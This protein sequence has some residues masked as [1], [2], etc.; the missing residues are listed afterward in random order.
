M[1]MIT[2]YIIIG[3]L[4][5]ILFDDIRLRWI[6][7]DLM[8]KVESLYSSVIELKSSNSQ[9]VSS[10]N[11]QNKELLNL[12]N[13]YLRYKSEVANKVL[14]LESSLRKRDKVSNKLDS[15]SIKN[16]NEAINVL[17]ELRFDWDG[18]TE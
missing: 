10:L 7:S 4:A 17:K 2:K 13:E 5:I 14:T 16:S 3:T 9:L 6:N 11:K 15:L 18:Q 12:N 8:D 1:N